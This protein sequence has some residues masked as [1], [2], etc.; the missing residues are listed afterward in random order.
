MSTMR[1][2]TG[3]KVPQ[4][5]IYRVYHREHRLPHEVTLLAEEAFPCCAQCGNAV[6]FELVRGVEIDPKG[7][8]V[9]LCQIPPVE[10]KKAA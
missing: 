4:N 2:K 5:G 7:F 6:T 1:H 3:L 9:K 8:K 10:G